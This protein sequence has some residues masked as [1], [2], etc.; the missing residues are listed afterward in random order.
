MKKVLVT[1]NP[2]NHEGGV[3][4]YYRTFFKRWDKRDS[5]CPGA[6]AIWLSDGALL[7]AFKRPL[8]Y[9][10]Y[11]SVDLLRLAWLLITDWRIRVV[12]VSPSLIPVPLLGDAVIVLLAK[13]LGR[14][15]I[16][17]YRGWKKDV[18]R[19]P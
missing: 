2:L 13:V 17:F 4:N 15:V 1:T 16:V 18:V 6:P 9:P 19:W 11:Y 5:C 8:L 7:F 3:V 14:S 12:Q 10:V